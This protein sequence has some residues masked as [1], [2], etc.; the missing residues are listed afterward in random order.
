MEKLEFQYSAG[1]AASRRAIVGVVGSGDLEVLLEPGTAGRTTVRVT[2]SVNGFGPVWQAQLD[3]KPG[4]HITVGAAT[5][6]IRAALAS[7]PDKLAGGI[8]F[9]PRLLIGCE[10]L[11]ATELLQPGSLVR[12]HYRVRLPDNNATETAVAAVAAEAGARLPEAGWEIRS[13]T[14]A[15]PAVSNGQ[16]LLRTDRN[17]YCIGKK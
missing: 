1:A 7:E 2:T 5:I 11:P 17:L 4:A 13:R 16:I 3:L 9:G 8:G 15:S 14:N 6:E 10:A 12:W